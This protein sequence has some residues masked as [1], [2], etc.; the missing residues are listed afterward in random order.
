MFLNSISDFR[1]PKPYKTLCF[2]VSF[3]VFRILQVV[4]VFPKATRCGEGWATLRYCV[5]DLENSENLQ[6]PK[7]LQQIKE[8]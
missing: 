4:L 2:V 5:G 8:A 1:K 6:H 7:R 3:Q